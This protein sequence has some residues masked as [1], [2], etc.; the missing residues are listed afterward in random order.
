MAELAGDALLE[1][2]RITASQQHIE[3]VIA[4]EHQRIDAAQHRLHMRGQRAGVGQQSKPHGAVAEYELR[5]FARIVRHGIR[6]D[7]N[8]ANG[9]TAVTIENLDRANSGKTTGG[10]LQR[11]VGQPHRHVELAREACRA[12]DMIVML[13]GNQDGVDRGGIYIATRK[14]RKGIAQGKPAVGKNARPVDFN[15]QA[16]AFAAAAQRCEAHHERSAFSIQLSATSVV[17]T[18]DKLTADC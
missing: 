2:L 7:F 14:T 4:F 12:A 11:A 9:K 5:R 13:V 6:L 15:Q 18:M 10:S 1:L 17:G 16:V 8:G 3:I